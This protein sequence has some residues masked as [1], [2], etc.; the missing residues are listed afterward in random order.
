MKRYGNIFPTVTDFHHLYNSAHWAV[1]GKKNKYLVQDYFINLETE[2]LELQSEL[3]S[4]IYR[5]KPYHLFY[6]SDPKVRLICTPNFRDQVVHHSLCSLIEPIF[7]RTMI[8]HSYACRVGKGSR[9][10]IEYAKTNARRYKYFL[11]LDVRKFFHSVNHEL[12]AGIIARK[13]KD[14]DVLQLI[15]VILAHQPPATELGTGLPIGNLT[16]QHF[17]NMYLNQLDHFINEKLKISGYMRY[18]DDLLL[19]SGD[20]SQLWD[21]YASIQ[22]YLFDKLKLDLKDKAT[23]LAPVMQGIPYL[24]FRIY[25]AVTRIKRENLQRS[26]KRLNLR[27]KQLEVGLI[28]DESYSQSVRSILGFWDQGQTWA[29]RRSVLDLGWV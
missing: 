1:S 14:K 26:K 10:A 23:L 19:F 2:I 27:K 5:P 8:H 4:K 6:I 29:L 18:M 17:A 16:S 12:L 28:T 7:E 3:I 24:G 11:K 25:P 9:R 15:D 21:C 13:I 22:D 20:K